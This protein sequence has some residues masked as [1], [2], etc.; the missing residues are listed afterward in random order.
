MITNKSKQP[1]LHFRFEGPAIRDGKILFDDL[2]LFVSNLSLAIERI[3]NSLQIGESVRLGRPPRAIQVLTAL[4]IVSLSK[5]SVK[6]ALDLRREEQKFPRW[7]IGEEATNILLQ[8][9][10]VIAD[11]VPLPQGYDQGVLMALR[12]AGRII[13][14]GVETVHINS[15]STFGARRGTQS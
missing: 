5:G 8:G 14:R 9:I 2:T 11:D 13:E 1:L 15:R 7:D 3:I 12:D 4:E 6:L 10:E